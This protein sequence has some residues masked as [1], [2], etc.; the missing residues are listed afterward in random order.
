[1][2]E[3]RQ[4]LGLTDPLGRRDARDPPDMRTFIMASTQHGSAPLPLPAR[5]PFGNCQQQGNP[6]PQVWTMR[7]LLT[8]LTAWVRDDVPPPASARPRIADGTLV[9]PDQVRFPEIPA[10]AYGG[11]ERPAVSP[12]RIYDTLHVLDFGPLFRPEDSSGIITREPPLVKPGSYGVLE[13]QVDTDGNDIGGLRS[14]FL[15]TP[16][17]TYTGWNLG[18]K[19]RFENGMCNLQGS[20]IPFAATRAERLATGDPRLSIEERYPS[21]EAYLAQFRKATADLV[22]KRYLLPDDAR[23]LNERAE[24]EGIRT[25]P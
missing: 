18:R 19:D 16:V 10:N 24:R 11:V 5:A 22:A 8:A 13:I 15:Q 3:G 21:K 20:F 17:G 14:V 25:A 23:V 12:L 2:W 1:M 9:P 4:S 6:N 7:A